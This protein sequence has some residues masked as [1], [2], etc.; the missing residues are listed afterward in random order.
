MSKN[1]LIES[2]E[3][4][5]LLAAQINFPD[6]SNTTHLVENGYGDNKVVFDSKLRLTDNANYQARSVWYDQAVPIE[7]FRADFSFRINKNS[8]GAD[9]LTF[10]M[11]NGPTSSLGADGRGLGFGNINVPSEAVAFN[12]FNFGKFGSQLGFATNGER[13]G[14]NTK[15][16]QIDLHSGHVFKVTV[17]YDGTEMKA[18]VVDATAKGKTFV[19]TQNIDLV[20]VLETT[21]AIVG[22]TAGT[23]ANKAQ[24]E[25][26]S[27]SFSGEHAVQPAPVPTNPDVVTAANASPNPV[28]TRTTTL[29]VL[30]VDPIDGEAG[31]TYTWS[32]IKAPNGAKAP[33]FSVNGT[34]ESKSTVARFYKEGSY[35]FR[36][37][38]KNK[39]GLTTTSDVNVRVESTATYIGIDRHEQEVTTRGR[40]LF[41]ATMYDQFRRVMK[42]QP[43]FAWS[44]TGG[45]NTGAIDEATGMF[46]AGR[47]TGH[48]DI[49]ASALGLTGTVGVTVMPE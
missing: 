43:T 33:I 4:R 47:A 34:N 32:A 3:R 13:P 29:N 25:I 38:L 10:A 1:Q 11:I 49:A 9:G 5:S 44:A 2:L 35:T 23:G 39:A 7:R 30:G 26:L 41:T 18:F 8:D 19:A 12:F 28:R 31:L 45:A 21:D 36:V 48:V 17:T 42:D 16:K 24:Q 46:K 27:W 15:M 40:M 22:F 37:T 6:F 20:N 14:T